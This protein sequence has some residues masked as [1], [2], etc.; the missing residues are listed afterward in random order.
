M[1]VN[2]QR[3]RDAERRLWESFGLAPTERRLRLDRLG[4]SVRVQEVGEGPTILFVHGASNGGA[5]WAPLAAQLDGFHCVMLDRPG[6]GLSDPLTGQ[7]GLADIDAVKTVADQLLPDVL[8]AMDLPVAHVGATSYGGFFAFRSAAHAPERI[9]RIVEYSWSMGAP[10]AKVPVIM[11][12]AAIPGFGALT[13]RMPVT[14]SSAKVMLRQ[15][16]LQGAIDSGKFND[17]MLDWFVSLLNN[18]ESMRNEIRSTPKV[19]T[20]IAGLNQ[21]MLLDRSLIERITMPVKFLWGEDDPNGGA[22]I[23]QAFAATFPNAE[24]EMMAGAGHAP[25]IDAP[26]HAA[27]ATRAFLSGHFSPAEFP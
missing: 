4:L 14:K 13:A 25:W 3:Y 7:A 22:D 8:D 20:P 1:A 6:C 11:R 10:M 5:S 21:E 27:D 26:E 9:G 23:A 19:I 2:E 17:V 12:I 15:V 18:T 24:L 16:G